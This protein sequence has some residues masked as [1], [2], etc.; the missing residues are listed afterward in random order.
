V[1]TSDEYTDETFAEWCRLFDPINSGVLESW[2]ETADGVVVFRFEN[3]YGIALPNCSDS[4]DLWYSH[5]YAK[6][7]AAA[8]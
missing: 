7:R 2:T 3:G 5:W 8:K 6:D 1:T 4:R